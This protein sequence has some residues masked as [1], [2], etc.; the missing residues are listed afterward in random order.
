MYIGYV[1]T[2]K[3]MNVIST[4]TTTTPCL[5]LLLIG[6]DLASYGFDRMFFNNR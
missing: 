5:A 4:S 6:L 2:M 3:C 1:G